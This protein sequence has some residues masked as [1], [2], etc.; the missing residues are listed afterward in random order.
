M[1]KLAFVSPYRHFTTKQNLKTSTC[2]AAI[3]GC[4]AAGFIGAASL[5][6]CDTA[7]AEGRPYR[8]AIPW[9]FVVCQF[10]GDPAPNMSTIK[11]LTIDTGSK[12]LADY[13]AAMSHGVANLSGSTVAGPFLQTN[14]ATQETAVDNGTGP[15]TGANQVVTDCL[16]AGAASSSHYH[17]PASHYYI[18]TTT[19]IDLKGW[20]N[21]HA[22]GG[23]ATPLSEVAHEFGHGVGL[24]HSWSNDTQW[25]G[26]GGPAA[27]NGGDYGFTYDTMSAAC[28]Y[29]VPGPFGN[30]PS[31]LNAQHLDE[32]GWIPQSRAVTFGYDGA[33][34]STIKL[35]AL[36][37]P[38]A[39][40][41]MILRVPFDAN[42]PFHY[43]TVEFRKKD[44]WDVSI[45]ADIVLISEIK[46]NAGANYYQ[47]TLIRDVASPYGGTNTG[48]PVQSLSANGVTIKVGPISGDQASVT[49]TSEFAKEKNNPAR[50]VYGP[51]TCQSGYVWRSA[52]DSDYVCVT[53]ATRTQA[54]ED[55][56]AAASRKAAGSDNCKQGFVWRE[57]FPDDKVC[58]TPA[59]RT[60]VQQDNPQA[61]AR[62]E[63]PNA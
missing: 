19:Q 47:S 7:A 62:L 14:T 58:V 55:N 5:A 32:L 10:T 31:Y 38:E 41:P 34:S 56:A 60:Q 22:L 12:G 33:T 35:A 26:C 45:P 28:N 59:T 52:D 20:E 15:N 13:V 53:P 37:H 27:P 1:S 29:Q 6:M 40:G 36:S 23:T 16:N 30:A 2:H 54:A 17:P 48:A 46:Y 42:D 9:S 4:V 25:S 51:N 24:E 21:D 49:V 44:G 3:R 57:A 61:N 39:S 11:K 43:Y 50:S 8:G 63:K 18:L